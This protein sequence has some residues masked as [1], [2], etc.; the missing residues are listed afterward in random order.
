MILKIF[1]ISSG[2]ILC[3]SKNY[4][5]EIMMKEE[6]FGGFLSAISEFAREIKGGQIKTLS[7]RNFNLFYSYSNEFD[8][9]FVV[10]ADKDD[11]EREVRPKVEL[12]KSEF[13]GR[14]GLYLKEWAGNCSI[15]DDFDEFVEKKI[16]IPPK[17]LLM[18]VKGVGKKTIMDLFPGE[19]FLDIDEDLNEIT[20]KLIKLSDLKDIQ[21]CIIKKIDMEELAYNAIR[22]KILLNSVDVIIIITN[23]SYSNLRKT[24]VLYSRIKPRVTKADFYLIANFQDEEDTA[25]EPEKIEETLNLKTY[26]FSAIKGDSNKKILFIINEMLRNS[27]KKKFEVG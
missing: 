9:I 11:L 23:S 20:Q 5:D 1:V 15:F 27:V 25:F 17:I 3:Y 13:I 19:V 26:G 6:I 12:M 2:G 4:F 24:K 14:Y 10:V 22:Y 21:Q 7:F 16:I 18:G 8:Y